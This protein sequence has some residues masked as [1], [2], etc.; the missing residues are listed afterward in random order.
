MKPQNVGLGSQY[1]YIHTIVYTRTQTLTI[2]C[3]KISRKHTFTVGIGRYDSRKNISP[4]SSNIGAQSISIDKKVSSLITGNNR[5]VSWNTVSV[6][7]TN[8]DN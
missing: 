8:G 3:H 7:R 4:L 6:I 1:F 5:L 2:S